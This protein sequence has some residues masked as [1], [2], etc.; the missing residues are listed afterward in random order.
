M[1][2]GPWDEPEDDEE[3]EQAREEMEEF[4]EEARRN[5]FLA[6]NHDIED[7]PA[8]DEYEDEVN[9]A[10]FTALAMMDDLDESEAEEA[11]DDADEGDFD[12]GM[13]DG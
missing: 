2:G 11:A 6:F 12:G 10:R 1:N 3:L 5:P 4:V 13:W 9:D 7:N 8:Y